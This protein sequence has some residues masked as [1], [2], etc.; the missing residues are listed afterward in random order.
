ME[1]V[2][3]S[4]TKFVRK[5]KSLPISTQRI[6][7]MMVL[8]ILFVALPLFIWAVVTQRVFFKKQAA[9]GEMSGE[10]GVCIAY[11]NFVDVTPV[12]DVSAPCH[13][14][15]SAINAVA[16]NGTVMIE[17]GMYNINSTINVNGKTN[18]TI[19]GNTYY[20]NDAAVLNF[21][22]NGW[23]FLVQNSSGSI[24]KLKIQGGSSNGMIS[25]LNSSDFQL[26]YLKVSSNT[27]HTIDV[28]GSTNININNSEISSSA[29]ALEIQNSTYTS[30]S[31]NKIVNSSNAV[32][33][34][35]S[36]GTVMMGNLIASNRESG[37]YIYNANDTV[38]N[39]NTFNNNS[40]TSSSAAISLNGTVTLFSFNNNLVIYT[41]T[42]GVAF[43]GSTFTRTF[44]N[45][46]LWNNLGG[47]YV[48]FD[49]YT[50]VNGN[51]SEDPLVDYSGINFNWCLRSGSPAVYGSANNYDIMGSLNLC[52]TSSP[53]PSPTA[54]TCSPVNK[55]I[56]VTPN[57]DTI[58]KCHDIQM[59]IDAVNGDGYTIS[60]EKGDYNIGKTISILNK[61]NLNI[62][63]NV[64][65]NPD[66][67]WLSLNT[68]NGGGYGVKVVNSS[69]SITRMHIEGITPNGLVSIQNST[70]FNVNFAKLVGTSS[71]TVDIQNSSNIN[72]NDSEIVSS[73]GGIEINNSPNASITGNRINH[74]K[75]AI[76]VISSAYPII[77]YNIITANSAGAIYLQ[78][79]N[80]AN[81][82]HN[83]IINNTGSVPTVSIVGGNASPNN[84]SHN[85][86]AFNDG[87]GLYKDTGA[88]NFSTISYNDVF[89]NYAGYNYS[90][91]TDPTGTNGNI[92]ADPKLDIASGYYCLLSGSPAL[93][94]VV[95]NHEYMGKNGPCVTS[96]PIPSSSPTPNPGDVNRDGRVNIVDIGILIDNYRLSPINDPRADINK[97]GVV[98]IVDI[99]IIIDNYE[100]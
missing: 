97:D 93:Y 3:I 2:K 30:I 9:S 26:S 29:G 53:A 59:A 54:N 15:Q 18:I 11:N 77:T 62:A 45:N 70:N 19:T 95:N 28:Q 73:A 4:E 90:G 81:I 14:I 75:R 32:A 76:S 98:N 7:G 84:F 27:S 61:T 66:E 46:D 78:G 91:M 72:L 13:D 89:S 37:L 16:N 40:M 44:G 92:S 94:G 20:S 10:P 36:S 100:L 1:I 82:S 88:V 39:H 69:G 52:G 85:I 49:D 25:I 74:T 68:T 63:G 64:E 34:N 65:G 8:V 56:T 23:G 80:H 99:G 22:P 41:H 47:N 12:T 71:H 24:Q 83:T 33:I 79:I 67:V 17:P 6:T 87:P 43:S 48:G 57:T 51:I 31:N 58:G 50:G 60:I 38:V 96:T 55:V 35:N 21:I 86:I 5:I 42:A